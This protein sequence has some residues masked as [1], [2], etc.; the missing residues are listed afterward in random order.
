MSDPVLTLEHV[1]IERGGRTVVE[2]ISFH[3]RPGEVA[4]LIGHNGSGK[5]SLVNGIAGLLPTARGEVRWHRR[6]EDRRR[7]PILLQET[8]IFED[9]TVAENVACGVCDRF[10]PPFATLSRLRARAEKDFPIVSERWR[11]RAGTLSGGSRRLV[12]LERVLRTPSSLLLLDEPTVGLAQDNLSL[13]L[14]LITSQAAA[15]SATLMIEHLGLARRIA[16]RLCIM[17][18]GRIVY[19]GD[20]ALAEDKERMRAL[21]L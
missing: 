5:S 9:L 1:S 7:P 20:P 19:D 13:A 11:T 10:K 2:D 6:N 18:N 15:G 3:L 16:T 14:D 4:L 21:Y 12:A 17:K 8:S